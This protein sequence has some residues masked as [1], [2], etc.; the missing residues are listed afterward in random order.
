MAGF[1]FVKSDDVLKVLNSK[2]P[3]Q[4][5]DVRRELNMGDTLVIGASLSELIARGL[6]KVTSV[7]RGGSP[8][9][10]APGQE[11]K[12]AELSKF[13]N[14]KDGRTF[15]L[16]KSQKVLRDSKQDPLTRVSLR[17][18]KDYSREFN[19]TVNGQAEVFWRYYAISEEEGVEIVKSMFKPKQTKS[20]ELEVAKTVDKPVDKQENKEEKKEVAKEILKEVSETVKSESKEESQKTK[21]PRA[22]R[23]PREE[24]TSDVSFLEPM[25]SAPA[26][27]DIFSRIDDEFLKKLKKFFDEKSISVK[28]GNQVK[29]NSEYVFVINMETPVGKAEY[30]CMAR[31]KKKCNESDLSAAYLQGQVKRL[32]VVFITTGEV[33]KKTK[34][35]LNSD[36]K[37]M[38]VKEIK[39]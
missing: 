2:G 35:K 37:G 22:P 36:F 34:D 4:P 26:N 19:I 21:T 39:D 28:E 14:E 16:L 29:K 7:K 5:L 38:I 23:K 12:L 24:K 32:P 1:E 8:F 13:L 25:E 9:Y 30:Y 33:V 6:A 17:A 10:Y 31:N 15:E 11:A 27:K 20:Q 3:L 18:I